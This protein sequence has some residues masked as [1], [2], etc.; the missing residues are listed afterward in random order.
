[1]LT[2][3]CGLRAERVE[4]EREREQK[5]RKR[6]REERREN[7]RVKVE[8]EEQI[9]Y[10]SILPSLFNDTFKWQTVSKITCHHISAYLSPVILRF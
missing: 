3:M 1:M 6:G 8:G 10:C 5:Q 9:A 7:R 2:L 4:T